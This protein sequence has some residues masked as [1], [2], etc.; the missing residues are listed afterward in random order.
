METCL[1]PVFIL[2]D[3]LKSSCDFPAD[4]LAAEGYI[5][6]V[7][8][9]IE[10]K[11]LFVE[12]H[13][14]RLA[15]SFLLANVRMPITVE[16]IQS[17]ISTLIAANQVS[18]GNIKL[19]LKTRTQ[20]EKYW[21]AAWFIPHFYPS[22]QTYSQGVSMTSMQLERKDPA[23]KFQRDWFKQRISEQLKLSGAYEILLINNDCVTEGSK[24]N[25]FFVKAETIITP[26]EEQV[27]NGVT[28]QKI[29]AVCRQQGID[30]EERQVC[31][32]ELADFEGAFLTGTSPK[33]LAI[34]AID[35][36]VRFEPR[37][38]LISR[39]SKAYDQ[40]ISDYLNEK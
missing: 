8:R 26:P 24:S 3:E 37:H 9:V 40:L 14:K 11:P 33:V 29:L 34:N 4:A 35:A 21:F 28:R 6:E 5:Y 20:A 16:T 38:P 13:L 23:V 25:I 31:Y 27:L 36:T 22:P 12:D 19:V 1:H 17:R 10:G 32:F 30:C 18:S 15:T 39:I 2:N 7:M